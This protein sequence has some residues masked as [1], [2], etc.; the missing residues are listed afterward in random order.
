MAAKR[1]YNSQSSRRYATSQFGALLVETNYRK[2]TE[3]LPETRS[4]F[5]CRQ[6]VGLARVTACEYGNTD[7]RYNEARE[8]IEL[9]YRW[10]DRSEI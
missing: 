10:A 1:R 6:L 9:T 7:V 5:R 3:D 4:V 8:F 2:V